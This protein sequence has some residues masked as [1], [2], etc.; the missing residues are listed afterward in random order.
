MT[1]FKLETGP[2]AGVIDIEIYSYDDTAR[3][4]LAIVHRSEAGSLPDEWGAGAYV[5]VDILP[6]KGE[7]RKVYVGEATKAGVSGRL[8]S[9][10]SK[11]SSLERWVFALVIHGQDGGTQSKLTYEEAQALECELLKEFKRHPNVEL[12]NKNDPSEPTLTGSGWD[13]IR[14]FVKPV[15]DL[16][17]VY[18]CD[19]RK[20]SSTHWVSQAINASSHDSATSLPPPS[21]S[22]PSPDDKKAKKP[23]KHFGVTLT[24][25]VAAGDLR[26]GDRLVP[27][28]YAKKYSGEGFVVESNGKIYIRVNGAD[29][30]SPSSAAKALSGNKAE[31]GWHFW[32]RSSDGKSLDEMRKRLKRVRGID[33]D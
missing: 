15:I 9:H 31:S 25:L 7:R 3:P 1:E 21:P 19:V 18:G 12:A 23:Q 29:Y 20:K 14:S 8:Q 33:D 4:R 32:K 24:D 5:L 22:L 28:G 26:V 13:K 30:G 27:G 17:K 2:T 6:I 10:I 16:L 11:S